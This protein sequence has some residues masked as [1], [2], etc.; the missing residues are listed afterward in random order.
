MYEKKISELMSQLD[1]ERERSNNIDQ[2][3]NS[4]KNLLSGHEK[5][6]EVC[7]TFLKV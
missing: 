6:M 4:M 3:L 1:D 5:S 2:Q 7:V